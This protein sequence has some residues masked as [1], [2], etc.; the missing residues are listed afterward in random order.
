VLCGKAFGNDPHRHITGRMFP[1]EG[2]L[3]DIMVFREDSVTCNR[4]RCSRRIL[5]YA[6]KKDL[7]VFVNPSIYEVV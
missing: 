3:L 4:T 6:Y 1:R 5:F 2:K 7:V